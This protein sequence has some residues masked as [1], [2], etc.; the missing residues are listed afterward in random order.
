MSI[1]RSFV[2][3]SVLLSV[4]LAPSL[5]RADFYDDFRDGAYLRQDPNGIG[6]DAN[7]PYYTDPNYW[8]DPNVW[9]IDNPDWSVMDLIGVSFSWNIGSDAIADKALRMAVQGYSVGPATLG[10]IATSPV[11]GDPD[12]NTSPIHWDDTADHYLLVWA[13]YT[14]APAD[15][16]DDSGRITLFLHA[17]TV[18]WTGISMSLALDNKAYTGWA[19]HQYWTHLIEVEGQNFVR[20]MT[21][22]WNNPSWELT[23]V[24]IDT[25]GIQ[26]SNYPHSDPN[27]HDPNDTTWYEP[28]E[29]SNRISALD[30]TKWY[31]Q[32]IEQWERTGY[33]M[34]V[35][36]QHD[37]N[38]ASGDPNGKY[39]RGA[40]WH[41][42]KYDWDGEW[43]VE[44]HFAGDWWHSEP[45][46]HDN[47]ID[48]YYPEGVTAISIQSD[49][50]WLNGLLGESAFDNIEARTGVFD[51]DPVHLDLS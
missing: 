25:S 21:D 31:G 34:L 35:Q 6:Y 39:L 3:L 32:D 23:R 40:I 13:Y 29:S 17:D 18:A 36:F 38:F 44:G 33:W 28:P 4:V 15:P 46:G 42:D 41:G 45:D 37:P 10:V 27:R 8:L 5:V 16:N 24:W 19:D 48:W 1:E 9:D 43:V 51:P 11:C 26:D 50:Q 20:V 2:F 14:N 49:D 30:E 12:P 22:P 7:D 47:G